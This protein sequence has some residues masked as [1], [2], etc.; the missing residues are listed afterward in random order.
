MFLTDFTLFGDVIEIVDHNITLLAAKA[1]YWSTIGYIVIEAKGRDRG[2]A[3]ELRVKRESFHHTDF[4]SR[5]LELVDQ[6]LL[7]DQG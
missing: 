4:D 3:R 6:D 1:N 7:V 2:P 5:L